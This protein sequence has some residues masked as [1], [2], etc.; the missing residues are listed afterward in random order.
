VIDLRVLWRFTGL[1]VV[2]LRG[3]AGMPQ[4]QTKALERAVPGLE[5]IR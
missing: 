1:K 4:A 5:M 2:D 3:A